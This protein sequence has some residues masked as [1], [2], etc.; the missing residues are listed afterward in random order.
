[1]I[2][3]FAERDQLSSAFLSPPPKKKHTTKN[4]NFRK[5]IR[6]IEEVISNKLENIIFIVTTILF[7]ILF[8]SGN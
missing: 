4:N 1:M 5:E 2:S 3:W 8:P 7:C 6:F